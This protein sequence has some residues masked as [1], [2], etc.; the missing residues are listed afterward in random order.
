MGAYLYYRTESDVDSVMDYLFEENKTNMFLEKMEE[1][2]IF[3]VDSK[4]IKWTKENRPDLVDWELKK[5]GKGDLKTSTYMSSKME[6]AGY[7]QDDL[8]EMWVQIFEE[9]NKRFKMKYFA[10]SCSLNPNSS[11]FTLEL[12]KRITDNGKLLSGKTAKDERARELYKKYYKLFSEPEFD[13]S[14]IKPKDEL[15][16]DDGKIYTVNEYGYRDYLTLK[17]LM[18]GSYSNKSIEDIVHNIKEHIK[19]IPKMRYSGATAD[20]ESFIIDNGT[21]VY[22]ELIGQESKVKSI[23]SVLMQGRIKMNDSVVESVD[24]GYFKIN[25]AG[26]KRRMISLNDGLAH[27]IVYHSP[28][29]K[30]VN[31]N[32][33]IGRDKEELLSSFSVWLENSQSLPYPK[34][35]SKELFQKFQDKEKLTK[36]NTLGIEAVKVDLSVFENDNEI[37]MEIILE[38]CREQGLIDPNAKPLKEQF[39]LPNSK[40]LT[41]QQ[42]QKIYDK[43]NSMPKTYELEDL[44]IKPVGLK[45]FSPN[46]TLYITEADRGS[47]DDE[48]ENSHEQCYGYVKNESDPQCSDWGYIDVPAYLELVYPGGFGFEMDL[49]FEDMYIDLKGNVG[50]KEELEIRNK[51]TA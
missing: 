33:I 51:K 45:L 28:S 29:I 6:E 36:L 26:N 43:L 42:V 7:T 49:H 48:F 40:Y 23:S 12:M 5:L 14:N 10:N 32:V 30:D 24:L 8:T 44:D 50:S 3:L 21:L 41:K 4:H 9:L 15:L 27:A 39:P 37:L 34:H 16:M 22:L 47:E 31:F 2:T 11:Y 17:Y 35:L 25:K 38:V 46:M 18:Y 1:Q 13:I 19:Y 20:I